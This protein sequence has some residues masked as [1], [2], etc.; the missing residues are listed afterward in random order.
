MLSLE[1]LN[2]LEVHPGFAIVGAGVL[3]RDLHAAAQRIRPVLSARSHRD[4][5]G[6]RR[7]HRHQR[8]RLAQLSLRRHAPHGS[9]V[10]AWCWPMAACMDVGRGERD[11]FRA[12][13]DPAART[14]PRTP[15]GYLLR[16]GMD[17][18]DLFVG[19]EGTLGV[20]TEAGPAA[21]RAGGVLA[22]IV[23]FPIDDAAVDAVERWREDA[24]PRM[25]EYFDLP[26]L[27]LL[28]ARFPEIPAGAQAAILLEQELAVG[29]RSRSRSLA[30]SH[31]IVGRAGRRLLVRHHGRRPRTFPPLSPCPSRTG[32]RSRAPQRRH[33]DE[34]GLRRP[35]RE[36]SRDAGVLPPAA[37]K[38]NFRAAT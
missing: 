28:R 12:S 2:R 15:R 19:S 32:Q 33:E 36:Q 3:L 8:Q 4:R 10:C 25:L 7:H 9:S 16:P 26:S 35:A 20:V 22:G 38:R 24:S 6:D 13:G 37:W 5:R 34:H 11:R 31:R 30:R 17:W 21:A 18:V 14:S 23:F 1:K 29:G 27:D